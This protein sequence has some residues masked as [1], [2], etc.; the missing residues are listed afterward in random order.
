MFRF[1]YDAA[2]LSIESQHVIGLRMMRLARGGKTAQAEASLMVTEK[3][4]A[5]LAAAAMLMTGR[6]GNAVV[7][8]VRKRVRSNS[9]RLSRR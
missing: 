1:W 3:V 7:A 8:Q 9:R 6:S 5:S 2:M 4:A